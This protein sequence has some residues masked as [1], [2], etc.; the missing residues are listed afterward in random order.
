VH[1]H[2]EDVAA[3]RIGAERKGRILARPQLGRADD[4]QRIGREEERRQHGGQRHHQD[5]AG[6]QKGAAIARKAADKLQ[7]GEFKARHQ[8]IS[9]RGSSHI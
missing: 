2:G 3:Q 1:D 9:M 4:A 5:Q 8:R 7:A 6:A